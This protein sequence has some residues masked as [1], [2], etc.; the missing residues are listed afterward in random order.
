MVTNE[1]KKAL[2]DFFF[3]F[4]SVFVSHTLLGREGEGQKLCLISVAGLPSLERK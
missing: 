2:A 1:K 4:W 3:F